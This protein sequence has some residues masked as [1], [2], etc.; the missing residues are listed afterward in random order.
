MSMD[1]EIG[2]TDGGTIFLK[3][4]TMIEGRPATLTLEWT[5]ELTRDFSRRLLDAAD[6]AE[7]AKKEKIQ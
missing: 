7:K 6:K 5:P 1:G 4:Y 3:I 2:I